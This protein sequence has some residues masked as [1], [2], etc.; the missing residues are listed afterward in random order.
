MVVVAVAAG[1]EIVDDE[2]LQQMRRIQQRGDVAG[3]FQLDDDIYCCRH[4][5]SIIIASF[6]SLLFHLS[7]VKHQEDTM[8]ILLLLCL[9]TS[10]AMSN[11]KE[12]RCDN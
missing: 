6:L 11:N 8:T 5:S 12:A 9:Y 4:R 7:R 3:I 1:H 2:C 10:S